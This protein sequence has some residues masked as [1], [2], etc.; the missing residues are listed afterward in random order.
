MVQSENKKVI[1]SICKAPIDRKQG[2][3]LFDNG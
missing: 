3:S 2:H 1:P